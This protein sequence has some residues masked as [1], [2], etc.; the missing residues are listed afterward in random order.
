MRI[1][2]FTVPSMFVVLFA[3]KLAAGVDAITMVNQ[4]FLYGLIVLLAGVCIYIY[5]TGF[6]ALFSEGFRRMQNG[7]FR[8]PRAMEQVY[9]RMRKDAALQ[10]W[11]SKLQTNTKHIAISI[12]ASMTLFSLCLLIIG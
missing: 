8:K 4:T 2:L 12:G 1:Y 5:Q 3:V 9:E 6:L 10:T 11:R 7:I